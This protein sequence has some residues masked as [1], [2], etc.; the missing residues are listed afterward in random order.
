MAL[1]AVAAFAAPVA[2]DDAQFPYLTVTKSAAP[3]EV[4]PGQSF[5]YSIQ[6][7]CDEASCLD[8]QMTDLLPAELEGYP[9][10]NVTT[11]PGASSVP[12]TISWT[13]DGAPLPGTPT[14]VG[15]ATGFTVDFDGTVSAPDGV[16][17][18]FGTTFTIQLTLQVPTDVAPGEHEIV[19]TARTTATNSLPDEAP[20]PITVSV[21]VTIDVTPSK[22]WG[23][24]PQ[25]F[26]PGAGSTIAL[27]VANASNVDVDVL[28]LQEPKDAADGAAGLAATNPFTI[29]DFTGFG[30]ATLPDGAQVE[31]DAYVL[32]GDATW[33]WVS[34]AP[35]A[36][37]TLPD[38]VSNADVG[39]LR[40][41]YTG[42]IT[43][44][45]GGTVNLELAQRAT[46]R[47]TGADLSTAS[48]SVDNVVEATATS[49]ELDETATADASATYAVN[50]V[51]LG[52]ETSKNIKP[53]TVTGGHSATGTLIGTNSTS[54]VQE[55]RLADLDFFTADVTFGGFD[56][57][58]AWPAGA[59]GAT[60]VYHP[61]GG[62]EPVEVPF[63][64]GAVPADPS[65]AIS[66][67]EVVFTA[68]G[69]AI[70]SAA[71]TTV[72][73][74]IN[75]SED[76]AGDSAQATL[77]NTVATTATAA[78]GQD[79]TASASDQLTIITPAVTVTLDK[80]VRPSTAVQ[81]GESTYVSLEAHGTAT[82]RATL[83]DLVIEDAISE[84]DAEFW[85]AFDLAG[86][87]PTQVP[88]GTVLTIQVQTA[89]GW[90][91]LSQYG[92]E[93]AATI[94]QLD[95]AAFAAASSG[96][97]ITADGITGARLS[98]HSVGGFPSDITVK[99]TLI[100]DARSQMRDGTDITPGDEQAAPYENSAVVDASGVSQGGNDLTDDDGDIG[101]G[102][103]ITYPGG[104]GPLGI[105]KRWNKGFVN[106]QAGDTAGTLLDWRVTPGFGTVTVTDPASGFDTPSGTV[107][108]AFDL[109]RIDPVGASSTP[110]T[111][112]W[113]LKYDVITDI[114][115]Y[116]DGAWV[117]L[118]APGSGWIQGGA[119][120]GYILPA[121]QAAATT[122]VRIVLAENTAARE[123]AQQVGG[124]F[125]PYAP[126]PGTGVAT[127]SDTRQFRLQWQLRDR[128]RTDD[129]AAGGWVTEDVV[130]NTADAGTVDNAV[131]LDG[132]PLDGGDPSRDT[133][134]ATIQIFEPGPAV[135]V[136][137]SVEAAEPIFVPELDTPADQWPTATWTITANNASV[138]SAGYVR[139][140]DPAAACSAPAPSADC[141]LADPNGNP[142]ANEGI[143]WLKDSP[144]EYF[145]LTGIDLAASIEH[146]I[147]L[148]ATVVWLLRYDAADA[149][150]ST[151]Q[152]SSTAAEALDTGD[153][154]DVVGI[155]AT[156]Q[157]ANA[158]VDGVGTTITQENR[159]TITL[160]SQLRTT[161]RSSEIPLE[162][163]VTQTID[164][165]NRVFAQSYDD[166]LS[167]G[168]PT[169]DLADIGVVLTGGDVNI[170]PSKSVTPTE[171][172]LADPDVPVTV[173]LGANQGTDPRS[174]L[175]PSTVVIEDQAGSPDFWN[176][177]DFT[178][179]G[180]VT[181]PQGADRVQVD[182]YGPFGD[183]DADT[184]ATGTPAATAAVP[185]AADDYGDIQG[186]RFT[187]T[188]DDGG[189]FHPTSPAANWAADASFMVELRDTYRDSGDDMVFAGSV[190]NTQTSQ[191]LRTDGKNS[192][193]KTANARI[194]LSEGTQE[195][196][197]N[198]LTNSGNRSANP[199]D[200]V[201]FQLSFENTGTGFLTITELRDTL[202]AE[203]VYLGD[204][205]P[206]YTG[207]EDGLLS[208][209]VSLTIEGDGSELV[210]TWPA[211]GNR[212][213]PGETFVID[214]PFELQ[215]TR[216]RVFNDIVVTTVETL[217]ACGNIDGSANWTG[218][219]NTCATQDYVDT[220]AGPNLFAVKGVRGS[221]EG[222]SAGGAYNR[223][224]GA[225]C[226][227]TLTAAGGSYYRPTCVAHSD[228]GGID[229]WVLRVQN[230][231]TF[232]VTSMTVF[233]QLPV[234]GD[235]M[236]IGAG[237]ASAYRPQL[238]ADSIDVI[239]PAGTETVIEVTTSPDVCTG[240][241]PMLSSQ[242]ACEQAG[243]VWTT[244]G[245]DTDWAAVSGLR[246]HLDFT[247]TDA[248]E[249]ETAELVD[250]TF[251]T[252]NVPAT[253]EDPSGAPDVVPAADA[254]A[255][256]QFGVQYT[257]VNLQGVG[258][259]KALAPNKVGV[260]LRS[261]S[262]AV[263]K[264][265]TGPAAEAYAPE[266]FDVALTCT[267]GEHELDLGE[268]ATLTLSAEN[269]YRARVDGIPY[270]VDPLTSC[271]VTEVGDA[272]QYGETSRFIDP[273]GG[274]LVLTEPTNPAIPVED[275]DVPTAQV[276]T[277]T[278][279][280]QF[281]GLSVTKVVDTAATE[282][283]FGPFS[284]DLTCTSATDIPVALGD[285]GQTTLSFTL[286][287]GETFTAPADR[288]PVGASCTVT[289][290]D[291][292]F[293]DEIVILGD[294]VTDH[295]D[296]SAT[297]VPGIDPAEVTVTN[298]Y[299]AGTFTVAK[300]VNGAG[301][302]LFG[303]GP[304]GFDAVCTYQD[305]TLLAESF[306]LFG[307]DTRSFGVFP[308]GTECSVT[309]TATGGATAT[310]LTPT[311]GTVEI[312]SP[313]GQDEISNVTAEATNTFD[314]GVLAVEKVIDGTGAELFGVGPFEATAVCTWQKDGQTVPIELPGDGVLTLSQE[315]D[316]RATIGNLIV[317]ADC[318]VTE[319]AAGGATSSAIAPEGGAVTIPANDDEEGQQAVTVTL[320]N[321]FDLGSLEIEK[322]VDG[323]GA[324]LFG[325]GP[326]EAQAVCTWDKD[327][328]TLPI[329]LAD[330]G[331]VVLSQENGYAASIGDLIVGADCV[332]TE[333]LTGGATSSSIAPAD[334]VTVPP[335]DD[336]AAQAAVV[337]LTNTFDLGVLEIEKIIE[338]DGAELFG[339][340]PFEAQAVCTWD[341]EGVTL[342]IDLSND[343]VVVLSEENGYVA[344]IGD[345]IVGAECVVTETLTGGATSSA[346]AP[347]GGAVTIPANDDQGEQQ[348]VTVTL[349]NTFDVTSLEVTKEVQGDLTAPGASG[350]FEVELVC[351]WEV[352]G[353]TVAVDVPG[354]AVRELNVD[355][356]LTT[357]FEQ[358][359]VGTS[360]HLTETDTS[361]ADGTLITVAVEGESP[362]TT[363]GA[364]AEV[365]LSSTTAPGQAQAF[366][367]NAYDAVPVAPDL[368]ETGTRVGTIAGI[369]ALLTV[370][371]LGVVLRTRTRVS[372]S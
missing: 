177:F 346:I 128:T 172:L 251:R 320:T 236:L 79:A 303:S 245:Q 120:A 130:Y 175:S 20:A 333:T 246:V 147:D 137:K 193:P 108:E 75:T 144:F 153:L 43:P 259:V 89:D 356:E 190:D 7:T 154:A 95:R 181:L 241:W 62:G 256:N 317:G 78:N 142:F 195:I 5:S 28:T 65:V 171:I 68:D 365:G 6:V 369:A 67:F 295:G 100:F 307:G 140:T 115:L 145:D 166:V 310:V 21:P 158:G 123:A 23:P 309:E 201:P 47:D 213:A 168:V 368:P 361:D 11:N 184:W 114:E 308:V 189:Y 250:V 96:A 279:D 191:S 74:T 156:F 194:T 40:L 298:G 46:N 164:V 371:G 324:E 129:G 165:D 198:K 338:G 222:T 139:V 192:E 276:A 300:N 205:E 85:D 136:V 51:S 265:V 173:T 240:T 110:F 344:S 215:P 93:A 291:D 161:P 60:V 230:A 210:F 155:S 8:A 203:L 280:Y 329:E 304:F 37:P 267:I 16:G 160:D 27:G 124:A 116:Q 312:V 231:G 301:A 2:A 352:D 316:Y 305:Q 152:L 186:I 359:P 59:T 133:D 149:T 296:G 208:E 263:E 331:V 322:V 336:G 81:P 98:F 18:Q 3:N 340:G 233:D 216:A 162:L 269:N 227:P 355:N 239:A 150:Y 39:G 32:G 170:A 221:L 13:E 243:E 70:E 313:D 105:D 82:D 58:P 357:V 229:D 42:D 287:D 31:V 281:T 157:A 159:L 91:E 167:P 92:P 318:T 141:Q 311:D 226:S 219:D 163:S 24:S 72:E 12:R 272:G 185:V 315:N 270:S 348:T 187:Y 134:N 354:G 200:N 214:V 52:V 132:I 274:E 242:A 29:T 351:S 358:L 343:G 64:H 34:G 57:A 314:L 99:P 264:E 143:D 285:D 25:S 252:Q 262:I 275:Q 63:G 197:V 353:Q 179:L 299:D 247:A 41:R 257:D 111:N 220:V 84:G 113:Y 61:L 53:N 48:Q 235:R 26:D 169:G 330:D 49:V 362:V 325:V 321:T 196:A 237:R 35:G 347:E 253:E 293:A 69:N 286:G 204:P 178:G 271:I 211:D 151:T 109:V 148:D 363:D 54:P 337:T 22:S 77:T 206:V 345:L 117:T 87:A 248:G 118:P 199:G 138:A 339:V 350:P 182:V 225:Q 36:T 341:K 127:S 122:G 323:E 277:V 4:D 101:T 297:I 217:D 86:I 146:Q 224:T 90:V 273:V 238:V 106:A 266:S 255:W 94:F 254:I 176:S 66:G 10:Q 367:V 268:Y 73:F 174:T 332:V 278:N 97:G 209:D 328:E 131:S 112:G 1:P 302:E 292:F 334:G 223:S 283:D 15:P 104:P 249:L 207:D 294:N 370:L 284:F 364:T 372:R 121:E 327:G 80:Q 234:E 260:H 50:P 55:L 38:G 232:P 19:N 33:S 218:G 335:N 125:D 44:G 17:L 366:V 188:R 202:P 360:C 119:F 244:V 349:T 282:G 180:G 306:E 45:G 88:A 258:T 126:A 288:I 135:N 102:S 103:V 289:E 228:L 342:P 183:D 30:G 326:F 319:T 9:L 83:H 56:Q 71:N 107:F 76:A 261:G 212:M 290:T 14:V